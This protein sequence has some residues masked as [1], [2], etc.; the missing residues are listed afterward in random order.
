[1]SFEFTDREIEDLSTDID[2]LRNMMTEYEQYIEMFSR[3]EHLKPT[4]DY[5][6]SRVVALEKQ[7]NHIKYI[8]S[9]NFN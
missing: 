9:E 4:V 5:W 2:I 3:Y 6:K 1:M 8:N 7:I